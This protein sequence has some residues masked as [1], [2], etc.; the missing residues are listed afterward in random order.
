MKN[1]LLILFLLPLTAVCQVGLSGRVISQTG[2]KPVA[3]A[4]VFLNNT[5]IGT[6]ADDDGTFKLYGISSGQ[7]D[8]IVSV[9]GYETYRKTI[10][11]SASIK[12]PDIV[13]IPKVA[14]LR[15]VRVGEDP[16]WARKLSIFKEYFLGR[17]A[18]ASQ[19]KLMNPE[20]L[21]LRFSKQE[22]VLTGRSD[23]FLEITNDALGYRLKYLVESFELNKIKGSVGY[24]GSV[25]YE[26]MEGSA[27]DKRRWQRNREL[28]YYGSA[29]HFLREVLAGH[30]D[31]NFMVRNF[32]I[33]VDPANKFVTDTLKMADYTHATDERGIFAIGHPGDMDVYYYPARRSAMGASPR[34]K[35]HGHLVA[36]VNLIDPYLFF[37]SNGTIL[38]PVGA[39]FVNGWGASRVADQLPEDYWPEEKVK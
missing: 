26:E 16:K 21:F 33:T 30:P 10:M 35:R 8:L 38:N 3:A 14:M 37:D 34:N 22:L 32:C 9:I 6:K 31:S 12:L 11:V 19:T 17:S 1:L 28:V 24:E 20:T 23:D 29:K 36:T 2:S 7:Y 27:A 5:T 15:E 25:L 4:S 13:M 18:N 39:M